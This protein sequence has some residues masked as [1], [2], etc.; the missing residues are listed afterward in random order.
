MCEASSTAE[1]VTSTAVLL[2][3]A[4]TDVLLALSQQVTSRLQ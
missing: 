1:A 3:V 4:V 2:A